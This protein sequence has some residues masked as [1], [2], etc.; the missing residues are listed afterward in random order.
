MVVGASLEPA[1]IPGLCGCVCGMLEAGEATVVVCDVGALEAP[2][3][4]ALDALA[5]MQLTARRLGGQVA[6]RGCPDAL[7]DLLALAGLSEVLGIVELGV[8]P[9]G[10]AEQR[11]HP[12][13]V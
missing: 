7:K 12:G 9:V 2:D 3:V 1:D 4:V 13:G 10:Q 5:R 8:E 6:L 11:K